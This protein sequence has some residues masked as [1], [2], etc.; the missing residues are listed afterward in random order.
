MTAPTDAAAVVDARIRA[1]GSAAPPMHNGELVFEAPWQARVF[2]IAHSLCD[3]GLYS[4][5][6][7]RDALIA[8]IARW[9]ASAGADEDY[10]YYERFQAALE[11]LLATRG[12][13]ARP[14]LAA[15]ARELA[16]RPHGHDH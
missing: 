4:W 11:S 9:E 6:E 13:T 15:R 14:A 12:T 1:S 8:E 7:F 10:R 3:A 5:D 16:A 2:G